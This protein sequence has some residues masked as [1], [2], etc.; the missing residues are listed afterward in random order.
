[1]DR[2]S[3]NIFHWRKE[4][5]LQFFLHINILYYSKKLK[6]FYIFK[7]LNILKT[8]APRE[9]HSSILIANNKAW[10]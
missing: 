5:Y 7:N 4:I 8:A 2:S 10:W 3:L 1:M 6:T 9:G